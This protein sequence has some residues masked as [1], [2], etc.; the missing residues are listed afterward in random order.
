MNYPKAIGP[1]SVWREA[2]ELVF[3]S[4]Q[5]PLDPNSGQLVS[6][7]IKAQ[8]TQALKNVGGALNA[9]GLDYKDVVKTTVFLSDINDFGA[10]NEVYAEFFKQPY[11]ARSAVGIAALPK[12]AQV[13]IEVIAR[14]S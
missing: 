3:F 8:A 13:E 12:G 7:D 14:K 2:G 10:V 11:P 1:Y 6:N 9:A 4:G 5:I